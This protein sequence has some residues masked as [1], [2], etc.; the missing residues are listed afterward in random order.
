MRKK[1][2]AVIDTN[3]F[4]S[5]LL[6]SSNAGKILDK[7]TDAK[8]DLLIS[9]DILN[10]LIDVISR[11]KFSNIFHPEDIKKLIDLLETDA[12]IIITGRK[13]SSACKDPKDYIVLACAAEEKADYIITGDSDLLEIS[14][15][16][17]IK[18][19]TLSQFLKLI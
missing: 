13:I 6:G 14:S 3:I 17:R 18:I 19:I 15:F 7:F 16:N 9:K 12:E 4:I 5:A 8:F 10:E 1:P 11:K 2:K